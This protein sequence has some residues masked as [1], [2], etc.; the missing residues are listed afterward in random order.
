MNIEAFR[1]AVEGKTIARVRDD[2]S[3]NRV[4]IEFTDGT[5]IALHGRERMAFDH[6]AHSSGA[7]KPAPAAS[8][9]PALVVKTRQPQPAQPR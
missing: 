6:S 5:H 4:C 7:L 2:I 1:E 3:H 9:E 8:Q